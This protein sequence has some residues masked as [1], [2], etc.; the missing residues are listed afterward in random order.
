MAHGQRRDVLKRNSA[1]FYWKKAKKYVNTS[2]KSIYAKGTKNNI[3]QI[4]RQWESRSPYIL[5]IKL[6]LI[7]HQIL[8]FS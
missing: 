7:D 6:I 3:D 2:C 5:K 8:S 1:E 4:K